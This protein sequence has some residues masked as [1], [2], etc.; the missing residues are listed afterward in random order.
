MYPWWICSKKTSNSINHGRLS[1][2]ASNMLL[3]VQQI[4]NVEERLQIVRVLSRM[5]CEKDWTMFMQFP[6]LWSGF[7]SRFNDIDIQVKP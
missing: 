4:D 1:F 2:A 5:F 3:Y 6:T 7:L